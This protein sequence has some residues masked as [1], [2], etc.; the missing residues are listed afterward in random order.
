MTNMLFVSA[1][2]NKIVWFGVVVFFLLGW[3]RHMLLLLHLS[4][5][6]RSLGAYAQAGRGIYFHCLVDTME[7]V[8]GSKAAR[9]MKI[10]AITKC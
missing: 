1:C 2:V 9:A 7:S 8:G 3:P 6:S 4:H 5:Y 10:I